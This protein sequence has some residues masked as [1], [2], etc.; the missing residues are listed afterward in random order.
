MNESI[1]DECRIRLLWELHHYKLKDYKRKREKMKNE[2][3]GYINRQ[4]MRN[5][6]IDCSQI[7]TYFIFIP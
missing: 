4:H 5:T 7:E 6:L 1:A 3:N 2:K